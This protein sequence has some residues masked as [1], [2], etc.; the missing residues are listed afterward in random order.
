MTRVSLL[1]CADYDKDQIKRLL[2]QGMEQIGFDLASFRN[3][4]V[5]LKP[6]LLI[7]SAPEKAIITHPVFV[8]AVAEV[9]K[10]HG[11]QPVL[12][13]SP[14]FTPLPKMIHKV[15]YAGFVEELGVEVARDRTPDVLAYE[16]ARRIKKIEISRAY[17]DVDLIINLPK[18]KTHGFTYISGAVKNLFGALPALTKSKMH[19]RFPESG[20]FSEWLLDLTGAFLRGFEPSKP[21]LNLVDA[22]VG[23]EG[24]GPGPAGTPRKI[25]VIVMGQDPIAVDYVATRVVGLDPNLVPTITRAWARD[26]CV[27]SPE[28]IEVLGER[29]EDVQLKNFIPT[30]A[31]IA[32]HFMRGRLVGPRVKNWVM[33]RPVPSPEKCTLCYQCRTICPAEAIAEAKDGGKIPRYDYVKCIRCFCCLEVCPE[34]AI[35]K[36]RG[37]LQWVVEAGLRASQ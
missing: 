23:Q 28:E 3:A 29:I 14:P 25:G 10:D 34:A 11:G 18:F 1:K 24:E 20:E 32:S 33:E 31:T 22:I 21:L 7:A 8:R 35:S 37:R 15:G 2:G 4:R 19:M 6:N 5:A 26:F 13:E 17:F 30:Q 12:I 9:V 36:K 27:H 16:G